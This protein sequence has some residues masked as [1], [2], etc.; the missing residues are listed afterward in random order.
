LSK[1]NFS[2]SNFYDHSKSSTYV[3][4]G[5]SFSIKYGKGFVNGFN[6]MDTVTLGQFSIKNQK[7]AEIND[8]LYN[9]N[10]NDVNKNEL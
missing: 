5:T 9:I 1:E 3:A 8:T 4:N 2:N 7:F 10:P 6:S